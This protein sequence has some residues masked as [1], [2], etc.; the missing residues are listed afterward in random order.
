L[1]Y[2]PIARV[3]RKGR[4]LN[5]EGKNISFRKDKSFTQRKNRAFIPVGGSKGN[6]GGGKIIAKEK[7]RG[8]KGGE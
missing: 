2:S 5:A 7:G 8:G 3:E 4:S 1:I 6:N